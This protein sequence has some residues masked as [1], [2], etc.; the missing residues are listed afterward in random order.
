M[1]NGIGVKIYKI[2]AKNLP[3]G[4]LYDGTKCDHADWTSE[5]QDCPVCGV[6]LGYRVDRV[7]P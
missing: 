7:R 3:E 2:E 1:L 4:V 6:Y 5:R